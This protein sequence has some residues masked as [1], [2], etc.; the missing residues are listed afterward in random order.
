MVTKI[1]GQSDDNIYTE[2]DYEGQY[3][4]YG[5]DEQEH[6]ILLVINDGS[7]LEVKYGKGGLAIWGIQVIKKGNLFDRIEFCDNEDADIYSDI[8]F[9]KKGVTFIF[10]C[11]IWEKIR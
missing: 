7:I 8:V 11:S 3:T 9:F 5:T 4:H 2:G 10:A 1:F 6:G